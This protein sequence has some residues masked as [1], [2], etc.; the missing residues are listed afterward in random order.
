MDV[1]DEVKGIIAKALK[2]PLDQ[3]DS[4]TQLT[5]LGAQSLDIVEIIF[6]LEEKFDISIPVPEGGPEGLEYDTVGA[7]AQAVKRLVD[8]KHS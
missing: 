2:V 8:A 7:V 6:E 1:A 3:L 4:D 5:D